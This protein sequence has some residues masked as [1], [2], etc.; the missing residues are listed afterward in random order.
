MTTHCTEIFL[1]PEPPGVKLHR[2]YALNIN[3]DGSD[4]ITKYIDTL[5]S[6]LTKLRKEIDSAPLCGNHAAVWFCERNTLPEGCWLC[7]A[8][9]LTADLGREGWK[10]VPVEPTQEMIDAAE[11]APQ[12]RIINDVLCTHALR[13]R[14]KLNIGDTPETSAIAEAYRAM[15][16]SAPSAM[17]SDTEEK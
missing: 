15:L 11:C 14:S 1:P 17:L 9:A 4:D 6:A 5:Q 8:G 16:S 13:T 2:S 7:N 12:M 3:S 10:L